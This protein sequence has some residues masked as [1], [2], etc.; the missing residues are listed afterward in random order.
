MLGLESSA[1]ARS[2]DWILCANVF[3]SSPVR[4]RGC[5]YKRYVCYISTYEHTLVKTSL[6]ERV[7]DVKQSCNF[8][9]QFGMQFC[10]VICEIFS[11]RSPQ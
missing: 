7:D 3:E 8:A 4:V 1:H 5:K 10:E 11:S 2:R 6:R 9:M